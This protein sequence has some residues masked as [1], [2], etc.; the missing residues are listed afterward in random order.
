M[1]YIQQEPATSIH[2]IG[3]VSYQKVVIQE[4]FYPNGHESF[5][6][7]ALPIATSTY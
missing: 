1:V 4:I 6:L 7:Y 3:G 2:L 5:A